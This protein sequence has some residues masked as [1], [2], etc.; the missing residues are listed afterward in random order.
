LLLPAGRR[1]LIC[2][3]PCHG[4]DYQR[5]DDGAM[6]D[7]E[8]RAKIQ[9]AVMNRTTRAW[10]TH[11]TWGR[12]VGGLVANYYFVD[13]LNTHYGTTIAPLRDQKS[14]AVHGSG[15]AVFGGH[16][17]Y[18]AWAHLLPPEIEL[19]SVRHLGRCSTTRKLRPGRML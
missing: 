17:T 18:A 12:L 1:P 4:D 5:I 14:L 3:M 19:F 8:L 11:I 13:T 9:T 2:F 6:S 7:Y 10:R 16:S 15:A